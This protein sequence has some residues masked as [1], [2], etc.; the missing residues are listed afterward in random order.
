MYSMSISTL[1]LRFSLCA[2]DLDDDS[3]HRSHLVTI[4]HECYMTYNLF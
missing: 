1:K 4:C 2:F 3:A